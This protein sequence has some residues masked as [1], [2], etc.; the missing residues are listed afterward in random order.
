MRLGVLKLGKDTK[1]HSH[2]F[3]H[4]LPWNK[5]LNYWCAHRSVCM[6]H[7]CTYTVVCTYVG[8]YIC[9]RAHKSV[10]TYRFVCTYV[11]SLGW[12]AHSLVCI[13]WNLIY[14]SFA[15]TC[16][17][18]YYRNNFSTF[19][20]LRYIAIWRITRVKV[21]PDFIFFWSIW[22]LKAAREAKLKLSDV[23]WRPSGSYKSD[24]IRKM[25][26]RRRNNFPPENRQPSSYD[27]LVYNFSITAL[28]P[29]AWT[30]F[31]RVSTSFFFRKSRDS[32]S[33]LLCY[34]RTVLPSFDDFQLGDDLIFP[35][36]Q[37]AH[38][39]SIK[40]ISISV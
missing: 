14:S 22:R 2:A 39:P 13:H 38:E 24:F 25:N 29:P 20:F 27:R 31:V 28:G 30:S 15:L 10:C 4:E 34:D 32:L 6:Q 33:A 37:C 35:E 23:S 16:V 1:S 36:M 21:C 19:I 12:C 18:A 11:G 8:V 9:W 7:M 40:K 17:L 3:E 5:L 26:V